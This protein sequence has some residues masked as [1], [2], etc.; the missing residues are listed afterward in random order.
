MLGRRKGNRV[1][2]LVSSKRLGNILRLTTLSENC[3]RIRTRPR[4]K[5]VCSSFTLA[6]KV[7]RSRNRKVETRIELKYALDWNV[8]AVS[9]FD[10]YRV[11]SCERTSSGS[12]HVSSSRHATGNKRL[13]TLEFV[14]QPFPSCRQKVDVLDIMANVAEFA[15]VGEERAAGMNGVYNATK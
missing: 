3:G 2:F 15:T 4:R 6:L 10:G 1:V 5:E 11:I 13:H 9:R 14:S 8:V 12:F 7:S